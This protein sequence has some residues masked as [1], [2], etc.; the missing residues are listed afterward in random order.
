MQNQG[1]RVLLFEFLLFLSTCGSSAFPTDA[2][3]AEKPLT[4]EQ[5][6]SERSL[7]TPQK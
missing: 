2:E 4:P 3:S 5:I 6:E 1:S 7:A